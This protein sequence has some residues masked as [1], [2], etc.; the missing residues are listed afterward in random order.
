[1]NFIPTRDQERREAAENWERDMR[2]HEPHLLR[3]GVIPAVRSVLQAD[4]S[5]I[6][7]VQQ[8]NGTWKPEDD[9]QNT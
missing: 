5:F 2:R 3:L 8:P 1:M 9:T 6:R 7:L 4:G